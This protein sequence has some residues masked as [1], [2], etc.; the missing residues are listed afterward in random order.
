MNIQRRLAMLSI[1]FGIVFAAGIA[2]FWI[3]GRFAGMQPTVLECAYQTVITLATVGNKTPELANVW[4]GQIFIIGLIISGM[5]VLLVFVTTVTAFIVEGEMRSIYRRKKMDKALDKIRDHVIVCGAGDTGGYVIEE[6]IGSQHPMVIVD[7]SEER[8]RRIL[9]QHPKAFIPYVVGPAADDDVLNRAGLARAKGIVA[10]LPD[11]RDNLFITVTARQTSPKARIV[12]RAADAPA[13]QRLKRAGA[14]AVVSPSRIG[15]MRMASEI[16]RPQVVSFMDN[17]LRARDMALR[18]EELPMT[19]SCSMV[20]KALR[21][22]DLR[23]K[24]DLLVLAIRDSSGEHFL[25]NPPP[26]HVLEEGSTLI[27]LGPVESVHRIRN[28]L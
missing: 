28:N 15:G 13:E 22:T 1:L 12:A 18:I 16:A 24:A 20:G 9:D 2:G 4:F 19:A 8:I 6:L 7:S 14:D 25:Y 10:A 27:V 23:S 17:M 5:G 26:E 3:L 11:D 21:D